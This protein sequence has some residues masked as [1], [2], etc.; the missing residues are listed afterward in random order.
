MKSQLTDV[1]ALRAEVAELRRN[2]EQL[3]VA[4]GLDGAMPVSPAQV[5]MLK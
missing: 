1:N 2:T 3:A 5:T 4:C